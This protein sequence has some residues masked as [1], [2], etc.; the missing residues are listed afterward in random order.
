VSEHALK[1][2]NIVLISP[3]DLLLVRA[4]L[5]VRYQTPKEVRKSLS[6]FFVDY[7]MSKTALAELLGI[8]YEPPPHALFYLD[9]SLLLLSCF[10]FLR[11]AL[12]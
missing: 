3:T 1:S 11:S 5:I 7:N 12:C 2:A 10:I 9:P 8:S 4:A 6:S